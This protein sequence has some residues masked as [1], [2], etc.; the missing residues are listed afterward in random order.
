MSTAIGVRCEN[1]VVLGADGQSVYSI[2]LEMIRPDQGK[3][4][5]LSDDV[6]MVGAGG[7]SDLVYLVDEIKE[8]LATHPAEMYPRE[9]RFLIE[10]ANLILHQR[11]NLDLYPLDKDDKDLR[12]D[13]TTII[14]SRHK[15]GDLGLYVAQS[16]G[17][18][19]IAQNHFSTGSGGPISEYLLQKLFRRDLNIDEALRVVYYA[20]SESVKIDP[21]S[22]GQVWLGYL[23][24]NEP[25]VE[26]KNRQMQEIHDVVQKR[27][28]LLNNQIYSK[29]FDDGFNFK[30]C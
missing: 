14:C 20:V 21:W 5:V 15:G 12:Y 22:G 17:I 24:G 25:F 4:F 2:G 19:E 11:Y 8:R 28:E 26:I 3:F 29:M 13:I 7:F 10:D 9:F 30:G 16:N 23:S 18:V 6:A 1:G 27:R